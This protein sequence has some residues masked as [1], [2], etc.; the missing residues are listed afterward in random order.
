MLL[1][2]QATADLFR[3][4][5]QVFR[6]AWTVRE[7][8]Q[9][10]KRSNDDIDFLPS[11][12][13]L[14]EKPPH[15]APRWT[16]RIL[17]VLSVAILITS[18][19]GHLDIVATAKGKV[20]PSDRVKVIQPAITGV[21]RRILVRDGQRVN[22]GQLLLVLD[23]TQ[24]SADSERARKDR[25]DANLAIAS[26]RAALD[27]QSSNKAPL[28]DKV[29]E[30]SDEAQHQAQAFTES[31]VRELRDKVSSATAELSK[32]TAE[33][34]T[35]DAEIAKLQATAP[36]ARKEADDYRKLS[37]DNYVSKHDF[38]E[39]EQTA[40]TAEHEL[41]AQ[42]S[43][44][45]ELTAAIA[46]QRAEI[47]S[48]ISTFRREQLDSLTKAQQQLQ[49]SAVDETKATTREGLLSLTAPVSGTVQQ[50]AVHT[51]GGVVT[52][53]Q[54][55]MEIVPDDT[56]EVEATIEN[57]DIGFVEV[58]QD[59]SVKL[60]AFPYTQYGYLKGKVVSVAN[61][62]VQDKRTGLVFTARI[63][64]AASSLTIHGKPI[65]I[66]PGMQVSAD[67]RTGKRSVAAYFLSPLVE[68]VQESMRER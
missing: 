22:A 58:G 12:L 30:A 18:V 2:I 43:H 46:Q 50:L 59:A 49:H 26:A 5:G 21:T 51:L 52:T 14:V 38:L 64:L 31:L 29:N 10:P 4:Y 62:A 39:K 20:M 65:S 6:S 56:L 40:L 17:A 23:T 54:S 36:L 3:R 7:S 33:R 57:K 53:A 63:K 19:F 47:A 60:D 1:R 42:R 48:M 34:A 8:L 32:R 37:V 16:L 41:I 44:A 68:N 27:A 24:A 55:L 11:S 61:D 35:A 15:P 9:G 67:I 13:E 25:I 66:T 28:L 45:A